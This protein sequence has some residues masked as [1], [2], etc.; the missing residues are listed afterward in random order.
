MSV[1]SRV[2][3]V[4]WQSDLSSYATTQHV[5]EAVA[6][7]PTPD[8]TSRVAVNG[9]IATNLTTRGWLALP[10]SAQTNLVL[11]LVASNDVIMAIG[12]IQ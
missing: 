10:Q 4:A 3:G 6:A 11:R 8:L 1:T 12:V 5:A 2:D 9:G 7:I